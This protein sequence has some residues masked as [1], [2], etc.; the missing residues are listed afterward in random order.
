MSDG[1]RKKWRSL[2]K[3]RTVA[4]STFE[5]R[6]NNNE[7]DN[8]ADNQPDQ[9]N[10]RTKKGQNSANNSKNGERF[11]CVKC[12]LVSLIQT[13]LSQKDFDYNNSFILRFSK[14]KEN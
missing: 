8:L 6:S 2:K 12:N 3:N 1:I 10:D 11:E 13:K 5:T 14:R 4:A 9:S 7:T